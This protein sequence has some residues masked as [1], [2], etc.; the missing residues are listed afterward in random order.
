MIIRCPHCKKSFNPTKPSR[1]CATCRNP[2]SLHD[3]Y[4]F[5]TTPT[6]TVIRHRNC[7]RPQSYV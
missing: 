6:K 2:I 7:E 3:K 5:D 4:Y 1:I